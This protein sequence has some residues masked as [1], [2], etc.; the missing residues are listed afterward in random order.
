MDRHYQ[1]QYL[2]TSPSYAVD[3]HDSAPHSASVEGAEELAR[4]RA[5]IFEKVKIEERKYEVIEMC[6]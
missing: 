6:N 4:R 5:Y 1:T 2:P 3:N